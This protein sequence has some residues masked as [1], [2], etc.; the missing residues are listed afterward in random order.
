MAKKKVATP[1]AEAQ[2]SVL[3]GM[4][5]D[6][7]E[8]AFD[9]QAKKGAPPVP[10]IKH[11][12]VIDTTPADILA[13]MAAGEWKP[14]PIADK[15]YDRARWIGSSNAAAMMGVSPEFDGERE[16]PYTVWRRKC[17]FE[18][19]ELSGDKL[20]FLQRRKRWEPVVVEMLR[21][22]FDAEITAV[23]LRYQDPHL[24]FLAAE[25]D[26]EWR[27]PE[28]GLI[29]SGEIKTVSP[30]AF[31]Q[32]FGWGEPGTEDVPIHYY[33][34]VQ[35]GMMVRGTRKAVL[36]AMVGID[37]M[38]FYPIAR[39]DATI[40]D[41]R[42]AYLRFW[43]GNVCAGVAP[44]AMSMGDLKAMFKS[45]APGLAVA[46]DS[47][48]GSKALRLRALAAQIDA[49]EM[50]MLSLEFDV[51]L[52]MGEAEKLTVD[53]RDVFS[54]KEQGWSRF[55]T[56]ELKT[57]KDKEERKIYLKYLKSG[58]HRVFKPMYGGT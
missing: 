48:V 44:D 58:T 9:A 49:I 32:K 37:S 2:P 31:K 38:V 27:D 47:I 7:L 24:P 26:F 54:W 21:E 6:A 45:S 56:T 23:N 36:A 53:G 52:A 8:V 5:K 22:E 12:A 43:N 29:E 51:K 40:A 41:M 57:S 28:T 34:Q 4:E 33:F 50:D 16:T 39:N 11:H 55:A 19:D 18:S 13:A 1:A 3:T 20:L 42:R 15:D 35:H 14:T 30:F 25:L 10:P 17:G 46:A